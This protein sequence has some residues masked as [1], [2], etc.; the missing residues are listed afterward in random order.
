MRRKLESLQGKSM[1]RDGFMELLCG[2]AAAP[3]EGVRGLRLTLE[4]IPDDIGVY[5]VMSLIADRP[6]TKGLSPQLGFGSR[7]Q[8]GDKSL[9]GGIGAMAGFGGKDVGLAAIDWTEF[10]N[11]LTA[12]LNAPPDV[13]LLIQAH[14]AESR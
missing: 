7:L 9:G 8:V 11:N 4:R 3:P 14:C 1:T 12:A 2:T 6:T 13:Y 10:T 5:L